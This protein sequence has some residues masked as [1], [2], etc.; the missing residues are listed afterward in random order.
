[1]FFYEHTW[2]LTNKR[3]DLQIH[4]DEKSPD[5]IGI[6]ET[7]LKTDVSNAEVQMEEYQI[8]R[9][10]RQGKQRS[11]II[12]YTREHLQ[13]QVRDDLVEKYNKALGW[14]YDTH[15]TQSF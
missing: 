13:V 4:L 14:R 6:V 11:G 10:D 1:M 8:T 15:C 12:M 7:W 5:I 9:H 2:G 3:D